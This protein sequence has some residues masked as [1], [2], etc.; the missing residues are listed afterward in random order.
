M[1]HNGKFIL[2]YSVSGFGKN[3]SGIGVTTN[4][5]LDPRAPNYKLEGQGVVVQSIR[6]RDDWNAIDPNIVED[7]ER[8]DW[9]AFG[10]FW[11]GLKLVKLN[12]I[13]TAPA[14]PQD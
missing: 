6:G 12:D 7:G 3:P 10:S 5:A 2:Y 11:G 8:T 14:K 9:R 13:W 4:A 1:R